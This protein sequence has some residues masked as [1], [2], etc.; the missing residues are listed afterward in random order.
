MV[1]RLVLELVVSVALDVGLRLPVQLLGPRLVLAPGRT[2][3][4]GITIFGTSVG[5]TTVY[6]TRIGIRVTGMGVRNNLNVYNRWPAGAVASREV[7]RTTVA[8]PSSGTRGDVSAGR[9]G[10]VYQ[11]RRRSLMR[12]C[13]AIRQR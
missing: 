11:H 13:H 7:S 3:L 5:F 12:D 6:G 2:V 9:D 8:R 4:G 10:K 1:S